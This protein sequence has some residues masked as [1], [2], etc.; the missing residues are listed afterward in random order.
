MRK[1]IAAAAA[2]ALIAIAPAAQAQSI[3]LT[4]TWAFQTEGYGLGGGDQALAALSGVAVI[5]RS[6]N[7]YTIRL[8][9]H[10]LG[11]DAEGS[12]VMSAVQQT[13]RGDLDGGQFT[14]T[15]SLGADAP[16][17]YQPDN[18]LL[19]ETATGQLEGVLNSISS[20]RVIF[21]RLR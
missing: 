11:V 15:C 10:E 6:G 5:Q 4:G 21:T 17:G 8:L 18:F 14:I 3:A 1:M 12:S 2:L 20:G 9:A 19:Q 7:G 13:C 16:A